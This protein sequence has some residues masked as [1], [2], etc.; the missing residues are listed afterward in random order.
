MTLGTLVSR[1]LGFIRDILIA[2]FF[3]T[4][5]VLE[6]FLVSFRLPNIFRSIFAEG[7]T[8]SVATPVLSEYNKEKA[9]LFEIGNHLFCIFTLILTIATF[10]GIIFS[11]QLVML[12]APGYISNFDKFNLAVSF[13][14]ITFVYLLLIALSSIMVS[15]L[16]ALRNFFV[17]AFNPVFLNITFI[18]GVLFFSESLRNY[19]LVIC[20]IVAGVL[21][22]IFPYIALHHEGFRFRFNLKD[23]LADPVLKRML[24]L[25]MPRVWSS[26]VYQINV[27]LDTV[28]ASFT[29]VTGAGALAAINYANRLVQLPFALVVLSATPVIV[30]DFSS[31]HKE[32]NLADFKK[33]LVFSFQNVIF[34]V[35]PIS[36]VFIAIPEAIID[37]LFRRGAFGQD[38]LL[39]TS[40][41]FFFYSFGILFFCLIKILVTAFYALKDTSMP[42]R[43]ATLALFV[44]AVASIILMFPL[45]I[46]GVAL[47]TSLAAFT[48]F[49]LLY[50]AL[51]SKIGTIDWGDTRRQFM[52]VMLV[53]FA[54]A[55]SSRLLWNSLGYGKYAKAAIIAVIAAFIFILGGLLLNLRQ[56]D[57]VKRWILKKS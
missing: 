29:Q 31:Y 18:P 2:K 40:S 52:R 23:S 35:V 47:G 24:R 9:K 21:E 54:A 33:L 36:L 57:Y 22:V 7:F 46:G 1:L 53:S 17:P 44:N 13:T 49:I 41:V 19:I 45:K 51:I 27:F 26:A 4:S 37:V 28:L 14:R 15:I 55:I 8:D 12:F 39:A 34:F 38:S 6:A 11:K 32:N 43:T 42:A 16:Y 50:K 10:L 25:F 56:I 5:D 30:V 48:N 20:V 3:G